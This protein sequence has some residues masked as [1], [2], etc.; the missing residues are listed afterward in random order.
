MKK[1]LTTQN[2]SVVPESFVT[3][4]KQRLKQHENTVY[5]ENGDEFELELFNPTQNKVL[6]HIE[7]NGT[8]LKSGIVLRPGERVFLER[9]L[10]SPEKFKFDTYFVNGKND[11]VLNA[12]SKNGKVN[13]KFYNEKFY[14]NP[15]ITWNRNTGTWFNSPNTLTFYNDYYIPSTT[16]NLTSGIVNASSTLTSSTNSVY[17]TNDSFNTDNTLSVPKERSKKS[18]ETGRIE[19][20]SVSDQKF[21]YDQTTFETYYSWT[22]EWTIKPKSTKPIMKEDLVVYCTECGSK[23]KKDTHKF[24]PHCG[25]KY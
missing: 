4:G 22:S 2:R 3:K 18:L 17:F 14:F 21:T 19:K 6:A 10:D 1:N 25:T 8:S 23:R 24:C 11:E 13:V 9:F 16:T 7:L 15:T 5:L 20:G 12:I